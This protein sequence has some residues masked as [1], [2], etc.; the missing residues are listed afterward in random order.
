MHTGFAGTSMVGLDVQSVS[1]N[2]PDTRILINGGYS[3]IARPMNLAG[4]LLQGT[5]VAVALRI[6]IDTVRAAHRTRPTTAN[7]PQA[8]E[9]TA[10]VSR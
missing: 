1:G 9:R 10:R 8:Q 5:G 4:Y 3:A 2:H 7:G 6:A